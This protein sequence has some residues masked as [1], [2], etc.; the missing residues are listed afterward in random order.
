MKKEKI[1]KEDYHGIAPVSNVIKKMKKEY[2]KDPKD[3]RIIG[4]TDKQGNKDTFIKKK[5]N[6]FWLKSRSLSPFSAL[7][8][9]TVV[10]NI[11]KD[12]DQEIYGKKLSKEEMLN[13]FGMVVP[14]K[15]NQN[16]V[17]SGIEN[18]SK[19]RGNHLRKIIKEKNPNV[20]YQLAKKVDEKFRHLYPRRDEMYG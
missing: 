1:E 13:L 5:P 6:T 10:R 3:W 18:F 8:M 15:K 20:G 7:S 9:G 16:I 17:A 4:S 19:E 14:I 2:D 12:I 11:D